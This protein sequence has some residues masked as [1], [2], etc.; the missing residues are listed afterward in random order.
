M[1]AEDGEDF[2][3]RVLAVV[4]SI[5]PGS[6]MSY[7]DVAEYVGQGGARQV[8]RVMSRSGG[9]VPW[10][11]VLHADGAPA[12]GLE[13]EALAR[14]RADGAPMRP[15]GTRVDMARA[16]WDGREV[17]VPSRARVG[18]DRWTARHLGDAR[19]GGRP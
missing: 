14:L 3:E 15:D 12:P 2:E 8:G 5:P 9:T 6:V 13:Q 4:E 7:G 19:D 1:P 11:R 17:V 10:W 18:R 16:R